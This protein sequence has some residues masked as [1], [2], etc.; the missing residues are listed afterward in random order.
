MLMRGMALA[1]VIYIVMMFA[2][3]DTGDRDREI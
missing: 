3:D 2:V 1:L